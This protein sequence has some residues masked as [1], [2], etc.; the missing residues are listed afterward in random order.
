MIDLWNIIV[1]IMAITG[2]ATWICFIL[3]VIFFW[4]C[5]KPPA[6]E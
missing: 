5:Q 1:I 6:K 3:L 2:A 4:M